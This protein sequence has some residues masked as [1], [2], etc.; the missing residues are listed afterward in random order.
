VATTVRNTQEAIAAGATALFG[1][2]YGDT[3]RVVSVGDG[4][5]STEL[6]GGTHVHATGDI[7]ACLITE[8]S[9]VAAGVRRI[10][11]V[12]GMGAVALA[13]RTV[14]ELD[15]A[16]AVSGAK[17]GT[18][19]DWVKASQ[20]EHSRLQKEMQQLRTKLALGGSGG[21]AGSDADHVDIAGST[22]IARAVNDVDKESLRALA[23]TLKSRMKSGVIVLAAPMADGKVTIIASVTPDLSKKAPAGQIVKHLA[24]IVGGGGGGRP[25]F[26]EAGG[27]DQAKIPALL[28]EARTLVERLLKG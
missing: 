24:P 5:F 17:R 2:K 12:T 4:A 10:E 26:A 9:G 8:D 19:A 13:R 28:A 15:E 22:F 7:G 1:E 16:L 20:Q 25:D 6:C 11:A 14:G 21:A 3:V 18:L 27:K 23:D